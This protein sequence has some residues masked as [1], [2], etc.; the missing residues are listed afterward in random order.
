MSIFH[1]LFENL[2]A[3]FAYLLLILSTISVWINR[4]IWIWGVLCIVSLILAYYGGVIELKALAP[5]G[6]LFLCQAALTQEI[7]GFWRLFSGLIAALISFAIF[8]HLISGFHNIR[9][10][11]DWHSSPNAV[12]MNIYIN[13]DKPFV[14]L[15]VLG[16]LVPLITTSKRF[17]IV[18]TQSLLWFVLTAIVL[19][20]LA[21][22]FEIITYDPKIPAI[23]LM[24]ILL[25]IFFVCIPEEAFL[26]GF[27]QREITRDLD[28][29][30]S[31]FLAILVVSLL[32]GLMHLFAIPNFS[33]AFLAF[34][35]N[36]MYGL[37]FQFT[38]SIESS[39]IVHFLTNATHFFFFTYPIL[40]T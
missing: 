34:M 30:A 32:A 11:Q 36:L 3:T 1:P 9:L 31:G 18:L 28:N 37:I 16:L 10:L 20:G 2:S 33:Y 5:I 27:L 12:G 23:T 25:Q 15:F 38:K 4:R 13:Y 17:F 26:R 40:Q 19:L 8:G 7:S 35:A 22:S 39:I 29:F 24:W 21:Y 6:L 14:G